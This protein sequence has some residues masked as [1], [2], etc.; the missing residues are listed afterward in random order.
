MRITLIFFLVLLSSCASTPSDAPSYSSAPKAESGYSTLYIYRHDAPP[1]LY[2]PTISFNGIE[3][4]NPPEES[5]TWLHVKGGT[6]QVKVDWS[7]MAGWPDLNFEFQIKENE[8][9]YL[10]IFGDFQNG[11]T[12]KLTSNAKSLEKNEA[13]KE[14][15]SCCKYIKPV[16][17]KL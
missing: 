5:Y 15:K 9:Y 12:M 13:E 3:V 4:I 14:L 8:E 16:I 6:Y 10:K 7:F 17:N 11:S 2:T 1:Y